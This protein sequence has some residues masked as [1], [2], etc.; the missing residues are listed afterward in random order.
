[1][2]HCKGILSYG[3]LI[4]VIEHFEQVLKLFSA[5]VN[6]FK[7]L[8]WYQTC[9]TEPTTCQD[10]EVLWVLWVHSFQVVLHRLSLLQ[11][12]RL[13]RTMKYYG[14]I[15]FKLCYTDYLCYSTYDLRG[16]WSIMAIFSSSRAIQIIPN[17]ILGFWCPRAT[18][19]LTSESRLIRYL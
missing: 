19:S 4:S 2:S 18:E 14:Y 1:M 5:L 11:Y 9:I 7:G 6:V 8:L 17:L 12:L 15:Q 3:W 13:V 10:H 16:P